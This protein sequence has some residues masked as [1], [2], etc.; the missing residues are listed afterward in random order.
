MV[1]TPL[2]ADHFEDSRCQVNP[3]AV[4]RLQAGHLGL[5]PLPQVLNLLKI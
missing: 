3:E 1:G 2:N 4:G 5:L